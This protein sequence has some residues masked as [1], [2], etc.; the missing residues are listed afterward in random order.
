MIEI[1]YI[2]IFLS[3]IE[4][5]WLLSRCD[6]WLLCEDWGRVAAFIFTIAGGGG[7]LPLSDLEDVGGVT[8]NVEKTKQ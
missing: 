2:K 1:S 8:G 4:R 5:T 3:W 6:W 7:L